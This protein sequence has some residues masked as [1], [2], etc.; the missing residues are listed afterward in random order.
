MAS[1]SACITGLGAVTPLGRDLP[2][3][4]EALL[5][6]R[7]ALELDAP[8]LA[9]ELGRYPV[10]RVPLEEALEG[11][12]VDRRLAR[13]MDPMTVQLLVA[14]A[15][16]LRDA[17]LEAPL[18]QSLSGSR[19]GVV[20]GVGWG[21]ARTLQTMGGAVAAGRAH[22]L[23]PFSIP[24]SMPNSAASNLAILQEARGPAWTVCTA[25]AAGLDACGIALGLIQS[26]QCDLVLT[27]GTEHIAWDLGV[28]GMAA[29]RALAPARNGDVRTLKPFDRRREG[30]AVGEG[31]AVLV[32]ESEA[33]ATAR[34]ASLRGRALGYGAGGDGFHITQPRPDGS[35][36]REVMEAALRNAGRE[37]VEV[38]AIYAHG[39]GTPLNDAMEARA[40]AELFEGTG[41]PA[42]TSTKGQHGHAMGA[43]GPLHAVFALCGAAEGRVAPTLTCEEPD[44]ELPFE[45]VRGGPA[46]LER[47]LVLVNAFGFGG[48]NA[49]LLLEGARA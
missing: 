47:P 39:T 8:G 21:A 29:A 46:A 13:R 27:G 34:G 49:S 1:R 48:H 19:V 40:I 43:S 5:A 2:S 42:V 35:G 31:A 20:L 14:A 7:V 17:G 30:T 24:A 23:G 36:A 22:R 38:G 28:G 9:P 32:L 4:W 45:P 33:H 15:E 18:G 10:G 11:S 3:S 37:P 41:L 26:G 25:C 44:P 12:S 6:G 16:A